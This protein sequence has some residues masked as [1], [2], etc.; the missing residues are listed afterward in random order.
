MTDVDAM[1]H[2]AVVVA[3]GEYLMAL[4]AIRATEDLD[5]SVID[6]LPWLDIESLNGYCID[7]SSD[8]PAGSVINLGLGAEQRRFT[9]SELGRA[10]ADR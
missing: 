7:R 8:M 6:A 5:A 3:E 2:A 1:P 4:P 9:E 10:S